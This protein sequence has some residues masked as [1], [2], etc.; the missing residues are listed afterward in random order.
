MTLDPIGPRSAGMDDF[1][2]LDAAQGDGVKEVQLPKPPE[3][4]LAPRRSRRVPKWRARPV[5]SRLPRRAPSGSANR[6][7]RG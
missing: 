4:R 2:R 3:K 5:R 7:S 1:D 6:S